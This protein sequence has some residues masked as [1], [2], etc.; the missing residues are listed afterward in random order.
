[1]MFQAYRFGMVAD[2]SAAMSAIFRSIISWR[3]AFE[4][5]SE[6]TRYFYLESMAYHPLGIEPPS[7]AGLPFW[8]CL[9][10]SCGGLTGS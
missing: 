2:G 9:G 8:T 1:V 6:N 7:I 10:G 4:K 5:R 3:S